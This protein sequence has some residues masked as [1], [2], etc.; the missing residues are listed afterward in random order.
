M[1]LCWQ[2]ILNVA[3]NI[4]TTFSGGEVLKCPFCD[5][6]ETK[7]LDSRAVEEGTCIRRR[8]EC[9]NCCKR[10]TTYERT[11]DRPFLVIKTDGSREAFDREKLLRGIMRAT[12][13]RPVSMETLNRLVQEVEGLARLN[14]EREIPSSFIGEQVMEKLKHVDE[15]AYVRF[16]S[17]YRKFKDVNEFL[18][19][20]NQFLSRE[21]AGKGETGLP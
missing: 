13:K 21:N 1:R 14:F 7:V 6:P 19:E 15:I 3:S 5:H 2:T 12:E 11:E 9:T 4:L 18:G 16:A 8:R 17:V 20:L 10:F